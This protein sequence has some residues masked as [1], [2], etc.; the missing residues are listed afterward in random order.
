[1]EKPGK[2][3]KFSLYL[4]VIISFLKKGG[5]E[6]YTILSK[7]IIHPCKQGVPEVKKIEEITEPGVVHLYGRIRDLHYLSGEEAVVSVEAWVYILYIVQNRLFL[8]Y[9]FFK[10]IFFLEVQ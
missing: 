9:F 10:M 5:G 6:K 1:M 4:G 2:R 7:Y 3:G 8:P